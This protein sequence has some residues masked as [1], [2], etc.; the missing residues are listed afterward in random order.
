MS[1]SVSTSMSMNLQSTM[2]RRRV[3]AILAMGGASAL[4]PRVSRAE[5][6]PLVLNAPEPDAPIPVEFPRDSG[7]HDDANTE[8]WYYTGHLFTEDDEKYGFEYVIFRARRGDVEGYVSHFAVTD[9][10]AGEF[11]FAQQIV[12]ADGVRGDGFAM[13]LDVNGWTMRGESGSDR[14]RAVMDGYGIDFKVEPGKPAALH[15]GDGFIAYGDGTYSYYY[16]RT[17]MP[18]VGVLRV[19][20]ENKRVTGS[21]WMDHQWGNFTTFTDGGWDWYALQLDDDRELMLYVI[22]DGTGN[23]LIVDGSVVEPDGTL[24]VL[25][26]GD[27]RAEPLG[28]WTSPKTGTEWPQDWR[29]SVDSEGL[30][31]KVVPTMPQQEMDTRYSTGII[32]WEG[33]C[34]IEGTS[35]GEPIGGNA[36]VELTGYAPVEDLGATGPADE[37]VVETN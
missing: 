34:T 28:T 6:R 14:L 12:G 20:E 10:E 7:P 23:P 15:E 21:A 4:L 29:I 36:Y 37:P 17:R 3:A 24:K 13:D 33:Q 9:N 5:T 16:S 30:D 26:E 22:H 31:L 25:D 32:Y 19:G 8:W 1:V 18:L 35:R 27:F 2:S 11:R